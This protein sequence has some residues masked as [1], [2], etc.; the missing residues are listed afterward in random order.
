MTK[1]PV[2]ILIA[3]DEEM[4][5]EL[6]EDVLHIDGYTVATAKDGEEALERVQE[7]GPL[8]L[9]SDVKMPRMNGFELRR[10]VKERFPQVRVIMMTGYADDFTVK[11]AMRLRADE[12]I[13]KP[14]SNH[15]LSHIVRSVISE[16]RATQTRPC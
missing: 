7:L 15:D 2:D 11:D 9:I 6:L 4:M 5:R 12:Y 13:I 8:L 3:D 14:F 10:R 1:K 16:A